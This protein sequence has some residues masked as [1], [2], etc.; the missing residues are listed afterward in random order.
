MTFEIQI[1]S[2]VKAARGLLTKKGVCFL[3]IGN[4]LGGML[5]A[6]FCLERHRLPQ[7]ID[8]YAVEMHLWGKRVRIFAL[9][10]EE[11]EK[12]AMDSKVTLEE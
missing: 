12:D 6:Y 4:V 2:H 9:G 7:T 3:Q 1:N 5:M 11:S 8:E 10:G